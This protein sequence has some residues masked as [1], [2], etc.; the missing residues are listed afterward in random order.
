MSAQTVTA[1]HVLPLVPLPAQAVVSGGLMPLR[2]GARTH[3][4]DPAG[5]V[6]RE[7]IRRRTGIALG[8]EDGPPEIGDIVMR[9]DPAVADAEGYTLLVT[10]R[11]EITG[12]DS[13][14][15]F[16]GVQ[17]LLQMLRQDD[18]G[19]SLPRAVV[20]DAPRFPYRGVM[21]D[22]ARHFFDVAEVR[23]FI[24][25]ASALKF[26]HLHL[27]LTDDQ[28]WR[29]HIDAW[30]RLTEQASS[31]SV[32]G[33][34]GG[35]YSKD[36]YREI[37]E[38]AAARHM[39]VVPEIDL[40]G[41]THAIGLAYP[42]IVEA[43]VM[44][45]ELLAE[46]AEL[47]QALPVAGEPYLGSGVGHSSVRIR[48]AGTYAFI[49]DVL[50]EI[51]EITPG[52]YLHIGGDESLGTA[53]HD[54]EYFAERVTAMTFEVGKTPIA[55]HE[56]GAAGGI[57]EGTIGQYWGNTTPAGTHAREGRH[58]V[59]RGGKLIMSASNVAYL[60]MKYTPDFP[61]GA[62]WAAIIDV[63][64]AYEWE[65]TSVLGVPEDAILGVE[66]PLWT[67]TIRTL[68]DIDQLFL[69]R[70]A[71]HAEIAWSPRNAPART[72]D[73][74]RERVGELAPKWRHEGLN[75]H[76]SPEIAWAEE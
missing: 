52:P 20:S 36:D 24:D 34:P 76:R 54:F 39:I 64:S 46:S 40:P 60:D 4:D 17:T 18:S 61:L 30:P 3:G 14:G 62:T 10:D 7:A 56:V 53:P 8:K 32:G 29:L 9:I 1:D 51:A 72:W 11:A 37:V 65:P 12:A 25:R 38:Y 5:A 27:H 66:A 21:L 70:A 48:D 57:A 16:Y 75:F 28:G 41:H 73:S 58:F 67:E 22:V 23:A 50:T 15:L 2:T 71:A 55:W 43:P 68:A 44:N 63:R 49:R 59:T 45:D 47:G 6:L 69:P 42:E 19:W 26:N 13:A 31:T 74:F 35:F 33:D